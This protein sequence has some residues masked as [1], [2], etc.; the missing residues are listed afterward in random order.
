[1]GVFLSVFQDGNAVATMPNR[2]P[3]FAANLAEMAD[4]LK[5][6]GVSLSRENCFIWEKKY[7][8]KPVEHCDKEGKHLFTDHGSKVTFDREIVS[9]QDIR[10][11]LVHA[12]QQHGSPLTLSGDDQVFV[13]RTARLA[14]ELGI[15][16]IKRV[17]SKQAQHD[18]PGQT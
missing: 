16:T 15:Q 10:R 1:M 17:N 4:K 7:F 3:I 14:D 11:A 12:M 9:D 6:L 13:E 8:Q 18:A 5:D 2:K